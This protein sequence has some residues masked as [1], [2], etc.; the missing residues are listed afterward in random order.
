MPTNETNTDTAATAANDL[1]HLK[2]AVNAAIAYSD[3][4]TALGRALSTP[5]ALLTETVQHLAL[6]LRSPAD[7]DKW[8]THEQVTLLQPIA[9]AVALGRRP[10]GPGWV[11]TTT[12]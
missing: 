4:M 2:N 12:D 8:V 9:A 6:G 10:G 3:A 7:V 1:T 5:A 11:L